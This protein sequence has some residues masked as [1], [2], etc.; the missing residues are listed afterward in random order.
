MQLANLLRY[1]VYK[2]QQPRVKLSEEVDYLENY[3]ALQRIRLGERCQ[4]DIE[5]LR[6]TTM[7]DTAFIANS[8]SRKCIQTWHGHHTARHI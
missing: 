4:F 8:I 7:A 2:G 6:S 5:L 3:L 1:T